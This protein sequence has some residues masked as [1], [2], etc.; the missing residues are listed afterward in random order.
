MITVSVI[1]L[2]YQHEK[3]IAQTLDSLLSQKCSFKYEIIIA[4]DG[5]K[6]LT[7]EISKN[8]VVKFPEIVRL[9]GNGNNLGISENF[10]FATKE[11]KGSFIAFCEGDDYWLDDY[12]LQKQVDF[13]KNNSE[14]VVCY[15][16]SNTVD[17]NNKIINNMFISEQHCRDY[18]SEELKKAS[19]IQFLTCCFRN[20][21][22][23]YPDEFYG[24][25]GGDT[26]LTSLLGNHGKGKYMSNIG[27]GASYRIHSGGIFSSKNSIRK[28]LFRANTHLAIALYYK[29]TNDLELKSFFIDRY[30]WILKDTIKLAI[31]QKNIKEI[32][33]LYW[34][35]Y[36]NEIALKFST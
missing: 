32:I 20:C 15:H 26:F 28:Q 36:K 33:I 6:D 31:F 10:V 3:F 9:I 18:T 19:F 35:Y 27:V 23:E 25:I 8:Y 12:K 34:K 7:R 11:C 2:T 13:L 1:V 5:S 29:R 16:N 30:K 4:E 21:L 17:Q 14:Y 24:K 22:T